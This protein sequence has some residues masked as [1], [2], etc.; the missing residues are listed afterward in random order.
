VLQDAVKPD[1]YQ[2]VELAD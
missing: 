2:A 1:P